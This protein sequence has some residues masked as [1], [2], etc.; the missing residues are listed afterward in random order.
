MTFSFVPLIPI[1]AVVVYPL[2]LLLLPFVH[3]R[4]LW[5]IPGP[6][7]VSFFSGVLSL[8]F[9]NGAIAFQEKT[10][11]RYGRIIRLTGHFGNQMICIADTKAIYEILIK[12]QDIFE[13]TE[14][15]RESVFLV[16][17]PV[18]LTQC[19]RRNLRLI[20]GGI[21]LISALGDTHRKQRKLMNPAFSINHMR[22]MI[23]VF[24]QLTQ[25]VS[26]VIQLQTLMR[27][28][29]GKE[30]K[31]VDV[32]EYMGR[33][34]LDLISQAGFGHSFYAIEGNDH[35]YS[36]ALKRLTPYPRCSP[37]AARVLTYRNLL[38]LVTSI[39][40]VPGRV[41]RSIA[42]RL[43]WPALHEIMKI[44]DTMKATSREIWEE[45][46]RL[47]A[48][49]DKSIVNEYGEGKDIM[50]ILPSTTSGKVR[51]S[52]LRWSRQILCQVRVS[53]SGESD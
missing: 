35:G 30:G 51:M 29:I 8:W 17:D 16:T 34:A 36:L 4:S 42:E 28:D 22:R 23:P 40:P 26:Q 3:Q 53:H 44:S 33:L 41:L 2:Y 43:P 45:K 52:D 46:K 25:R 39:I 10:M 37:A 38:P 49:G 31:E 50:S 14:A 13:E 32:T 15:I 6:S 18:L 21:G 5:S 48:L 1:A 47:Y 24:R 19:A 20:F 7:S 11:E 12:N 9:G 27:A